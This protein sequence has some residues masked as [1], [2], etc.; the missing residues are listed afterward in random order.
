M[1]PSNGLPN[2]FWSWIGNH[3]QG[4]W[5]MGS[6]Q[7]K[8]V[9]KIIKTN[10]MNWPVR[11]CTNLNNIRCLYHFFWCKTVWIAARLQQSLFG[12]GLPIHPNKQ[13]PGWWHIQRRNGLLLDVL[14]DSFC[15]LQSQTLQGCYIFLWTLWGKTALPVPKRVIQERVTR[16]ATI[17]LHVTGRIAWAFGA[18]RHQR[19][20]G[21]CTHLGPAHHK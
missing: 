19:G 6:K 8:I 12:C 10:H 2:R 20:L 5:C 1:S 7:I 17:G 18:A 4:R 11:I 15:K 13:V 9:I 21:M 16:L 14:R 3:I